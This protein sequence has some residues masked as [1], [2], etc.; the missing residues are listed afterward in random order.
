MQ[1]EPWLSRDKAM[2]DMVKSGRYRKGQDVRSGRADPEL[3]AVA[4]RR[5]PARPAMTGASPRRSTM[6]PL[7]GA[8]LTGGGRGPGPASPIDTYPWKTAAWLQLRVLQREHLGTGQSYLMAIKDKGRPPF[9]G[10]TATG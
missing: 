7:G 5:M 9:D 8:C 1:C 10:G 3:E 6:G 4:A 2:I